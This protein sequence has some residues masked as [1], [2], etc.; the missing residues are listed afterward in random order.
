MVPPFAA[1]DKFTANANGPTV[2]FYFI[3]NM[4]YKIS[5]IHL[6]GHIDTKKNEASP[7]FTAVPSSFCY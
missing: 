5:I 2:K 3:P 4:K 6:K 7:D 1:P